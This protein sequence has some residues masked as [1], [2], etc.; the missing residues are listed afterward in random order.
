MSDLHHLSAQLLP[1]PY[2]EGS[3]A[4][5]RFTRKAAESAVDFLSI[6]CLKML[7]GQ[8]VHASGLL[9]YLSDGPQPTMIISRQARQIIEEAYHESYWT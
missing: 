6:A 7:T 5:D 3:K 1:V 9:G 2:G 8:A 4:N